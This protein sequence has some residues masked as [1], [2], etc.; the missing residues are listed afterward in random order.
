MALSNAQLAIKRK[1]LELKAQALT[2]QVN[3]QK[4]REAADAAKKKLADHK[5]TTK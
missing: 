2:A 3:L 5:Q 4:A 1:E